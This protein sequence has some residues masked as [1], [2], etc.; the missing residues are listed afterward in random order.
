[1][2]DLNQAGLCPVSILGEQVSMLSPYG[3]RVVV[4]LGVPGVGRRT[5]KR[6]LLNH[7]PQYFTTATPC[8]LTY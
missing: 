3:R 2:I 4:L 8:K 6:M 7:L 1:M 5:L